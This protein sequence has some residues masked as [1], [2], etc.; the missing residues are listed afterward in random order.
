MGKPFTLIVSKLSPFMNVFHLV[1][2]VQD[3]CDFVRVQAKRISL[4]IRDLD[5]DRPESPQCSGSLYL[6]AYVTANVGPS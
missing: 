5:N 6:K 2:G 3:Q 1:G 4:I